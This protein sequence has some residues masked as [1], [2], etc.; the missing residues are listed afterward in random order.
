M[1][2]L[3]QVPPQLVETL[4][5]SGKLNWWKSRGGAGAVRQSTED[6]QRCDNGCSVSY[7]N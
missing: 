6:L 5:N 3:N 4:G 7:C 1:V 2:A